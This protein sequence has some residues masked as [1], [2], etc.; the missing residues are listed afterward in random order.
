[1]EKVE[2]KFKLVE[3]DQREKVEHVVFL[4]IYCVGNCVVGLAATVEPHL[5]LDVHFFPSA[6]ATADPTEQAM[7]A[8]STSPEGLSLAAHF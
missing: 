7:A 4:V 5:S 3:E 2:E 6:T 1:L 8:S